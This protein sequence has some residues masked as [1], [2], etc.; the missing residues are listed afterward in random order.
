[1]NKKFIRIVTALLTVVMA[2]LPAMTACQDQSPACSTCKDTNA[3]GVCDVC[4]EAL[5]ATAPADTTTAEVETTTPAPVE[6]DVQMTIRDQEGNA[7]AGALIRFTT[8]E[9]EDKTVTTGENGTAT[10]R[11]P[12]GLY[13]AYFDELPGNMIGAPTGVTVSVDMEPLALE[14]VD[15]TPNGT[16]D[17]PFV[18]NESTQNATVPA[19][20]SHYYSMFSGDRRTVYIESAVV[21]VLLNGTTYTA[22]ETGVIAIR[23][24][25]ENARDHINFCI[26]NK[27]EADAQIVIRVESDPGAMDNPIPVPSLGETMTASVTKDIIMYYAWTAT[28]DGVLTLTSTSDN[29]NISMSNLTSMQVTNFTNGALIA[30]LDVKAGET[31]S[32]TVSAVSVAAGETVSIPFALTLSPAEAE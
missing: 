27:S 5:Y 30:T 2:A 20:A 24:V 10:L 8:S 1:M 26:Q 17:R 28:E 25:G 22:D 13:I 7:V 12:V 21:E 15:N 29:N 19:G 16:A 18:V 23:I 14:V 4:G 6:V 32:I 31:V 3:D 9:Q 11:L